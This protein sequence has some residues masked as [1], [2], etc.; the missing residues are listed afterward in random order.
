MNA[1]LPS[2][3]KLLCGGLATLLGVS[4]C[5]LIPTYQRPE[6]PVSA[7]YPDASA[8]DASRLANVADLGWR[9][10]FADARLQ[11][12]IEL[13]LANNRDLRVAI[14]NIEKSRAQY[15]IQRSAQFP[16]ID[17]SGSND[18][19]RL[20][21]SVVGSETG[22]A[23]AGSGAVISRSSSVSVG[24]SSYELDFFGRIASLKAQALEDFL[25]TEEARRSTHISLVAEIATDYLTL[26]ADRERLAL[27]RQTLQSQ[28]ASYD[29]NKR[30]LEVGVITA[31]ALRQI[32]TSVD[33]AR[34]DVA[35]YKSLVAQDINLLTLMV[36]SPLPDELLHGELTPSI[37]TVTPDEVPEG[38]PS[39]LLT[40]RP[41]ILQ[42][43][44][45]LRGYNAAIGAARANFFPRIT[46]TASAGTA[47]SSLDGLFKGG[48]GTWNFGPSISLPIFDAGANRARLDSARTDRD[49]G[50]AN[51]E[52][53]IQTA[54]REVADALAE[55]N[56]LGDQLSA[57]QSLVDATSDSFRLSQAR[58]K[59]GV[60]SYLSVLDSQRSLYSAQQT[61]ITTRLSRIS[62]L[63]TLYKVLGGG[64]SET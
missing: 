53:A 9:K 62:N 52:K 10:V 8:S 63:V 27:A 16:E 39:D 15:R 58:F 32:Q 13:G 41:D 18:T 42:A 6:A 14:L 1:S 35:R 36:G 19:Q 49:I 33:T 46:L 26:A 61:L 50:V 23:T 25:A 37:L 54:F 34:V 48:S 17:V 30:S 28:S 4:A 2:R 55:R 57:Q 12:L 3:A 38:L 11:R 59:G 43:E 7:R 24:L 40:R 44:R 29:L 5:S 64:W 22:G 20:P 47:S 21:A 31:L 56:N 51:Y 60:D 45:T